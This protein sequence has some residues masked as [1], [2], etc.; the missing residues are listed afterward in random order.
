MSDKVMTR[1]QLAEMVQA[2][3]KDFIGAELA[4]LIRK[5]I[6][7]AVTPLRQ[8]MTSW[9][10]KVTDRAAEPSVAANW[11]DVPPGT[12]TRGL[13]LSR[14]VRASAL[15]RINGMGPEGAIQV[16][17]SWG[18]KNLA[19]MW[20]DARSKAMTAGDATAGGYLVPTQFINDFIGVLRSKTVI[21]ALGTPTIPIA[22]TAE[23]PKATAGATAN[24]G[25]ENTNA[26]KSEVSTGQLTLSFKKLRSLVPIGNSL[27]RYN[28]IGADVI[29]RNDMS[30]AMSTT[31][32]SKFI[33]GDGTD[34][35]PKGLRYWAV[36]ANVIA[37]NT[38]LSLANTF[39]DLGKLMQQLMGA[40]IP[41]SR[42]SWI[43]A[44]RIYNFLVT[45]L[46]SNGVPAFK[47]EMVSSKT[48]WG[49]PFGV[50]TGIPT[51]LDFTGSDTDD[52]SE[53]YFVDIDQCLIGEGET[54]SIE[55]SREAAYHDGS[56]VQSAWSRDETVVRAIAEHDFVLRYDK[57]V[58]ILAG[59]DWA[60]GSV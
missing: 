17:R 29:V 41:M 58:A 16:L 6:E 14:C 57:A 11:K 21:R 42:P 28:A 43:F 35:S 23:I 20:A 50:T 54:M 60:P 40:D 24:Y 36:N 2:Q 31:E 47:D 3:V 32:D 25:G 52:E 15:A 44:P 38:T 46:N 12:D 39:S 7:E 1:G 56:A 19:E 51:N 18:D 34:G 33:R 4:E 10:E 22:G 9:G 26:P 55:A 13:A 49:Y 27:L 53:V 48:L 30:A 45:I 8:K 5:N 37:A 59:V